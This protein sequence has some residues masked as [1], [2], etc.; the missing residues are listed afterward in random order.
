MEVP[1]ITS[2]P[3]ANDDPSSTPEEHAVDIHK[4]KPVHSIR[5]FLSEIGVIVVGIAIALTGEQLVEQ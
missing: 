2:D 5:E 4:P 3:A 1:E